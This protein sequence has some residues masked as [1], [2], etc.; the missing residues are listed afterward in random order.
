MARV[1]DIDMLVGV[2]EL[3]YCVSGEPGGHLLGEG[4]LLKRV[5]FMDMCAFEPEAYKLFWEVLVLYVSTEGF[6]QLWSL[7]E[8]KC[9]L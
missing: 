6:C 1:V 8:F 9:I 5:R 3:E 7:F 4:F 2:R